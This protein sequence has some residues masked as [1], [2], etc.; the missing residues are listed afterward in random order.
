MIH[1]YIDTTNLEPVSLNF[2]KK[3]KGKEDKHEYH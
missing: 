2:E 1:R 3:K